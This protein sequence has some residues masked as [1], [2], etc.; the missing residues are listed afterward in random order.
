MLSSLDPVR[1]RTPLLKC[2]CSQTPS[3]RRRALLAALRWALLLVVA[4]QVSC[5]GGSVAINS[6]SPLQITVSVSPSTA[7]VP[8]GESAP[9]VAT[10]GNSSNLAVSW[11]VN[12]L[13]GGNPVIGTISATG[14]NTASFTAPIN[15]PN[16][17]TVTVQAIPQADQTK[18]GSASVTIT[19]PPPPTL[20]ISPSSASVPVDGVLPFTA[21]V[22][23][24]SSGVLWEVDNLS[25]GNSTIGTISAS[26]L[27]AVYKA[28]AQ[29]PTIPVSVTAILLVD[30]SVSSSAAIMVTP[31]APPAVVVTVSPPT[32]SIAIGQAFQFAAAVQNSASGLIWQ[33]NHIS[34]G[35]STVGTITP[36]G[37]LTAA[38]QA[39]TSLP[40]PPGVTVSAVLQSDSTVFGSAGVTLTPPDAVAGVFSWRNDDGLT[41][42]NRQETILTP[43][44]VSS[45]GFGKRFS[46]PVDGYV[47]AQ[48]LY[49]S[50][51][52]A[53]GTTQNVVFVATENDSVY[54]FDADA[55][56]CWQ[57]WHTSFLTPGVTPVCQPNCSSDVGSDNLGPQ[58]GITGTPVIDPRTATLYV[59]AET[60]EGGNFVHRLHALDL[61]TGNEKSGGPVQI[62]ATV[63]RTVG[64]GS[65]TFD[66]QRANQR[67]A[68]QLIR[69]ASGKT[70]VL[71]AYGGYDESGDYNGWLFAYDAATLTQVAVLNTT[72]DGE[73][74]GI[75]QSGAAPSVDANGNI[76]VVVGNG[77]F[78]AG[79]ASPPQDDFAETLLRLQIDSR[80]AKFD[81]QDRFTPFNQTA[82]TLQAQDFG[83]AG[84]LLLP[85][86][87][88]SAAHPH[89][90]LAGGKEGKLYLIDRDALG[91]YSPPPGPDRVVQTL[92]LDSGGI[93][94]TPAYFEGTNMIY[95]AGAY[96]FLKAF[97]LTGGAFATPGC[98]SAAA[99]ALQSSEGFAFPGA[100][101]AISS[102]G[103]NGAIVWVLDTSGFGGSSSPALPAVLYAYDAN[104][105][106]K[107]YQSSPALGDPDAAGPAVKFVVPT[108]ANGKVYVGTQN[109]LS[110]FGLP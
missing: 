65:V 16:S 64:T 71:I 42:Q 110:V 2:A 99:P 21:N 108:V 96:D 55:N 49:A 6:A 5:N 79:S 48:P 97:P 89:L 33:V 23:N 67:A 74:G 85:D 61:V 82:L 51:V 15:V 40:S 4:E 98:P 92:C 56:P 90:G 100:S 70:S 39:P 76:F 43:A 28:P 30:P 50:N 24:S 3:C 34:G 77:T 53:G 75:W 32:A 54:A 63:P 102:N 47:F 73:Q 83:S 11:Q 81:L 94:G 31:A 22:Q 69:D 106:S 8:I 25:G 52:A 45:G 46:C 107:L 41:G 84:V 62:R 13:P 35:N 36:S 104:G 27:A 101:P 95:V 7:Q 38:Y 105:L 68:L 66:P 9:F 60:K 80:S 20:S 37:P 91:G 103:L 44:T 29:V 88:G 72:P 19:P 18:L 58:I 87:A 59:V 14:P 78:D 17:P 10:V 93:Y 109:E 86:Q 26:G 12:G 1:F 57:L